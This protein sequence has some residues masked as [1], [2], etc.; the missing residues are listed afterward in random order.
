MKRLAL[1]LFLFAL[2]PG[3]ALA[4]AVTGVG[5][6]L[7]LSL[8]P[9]QAVVG[10]QLEVSDMVTDLD[11]VPDIELGFGDDATV[12]ALNLDLHYRFRLQGSSWAPYV[13]MGMGV[14][15]IEVD[16]P[17]PFEDVSDTEVGGNFILGAQV[18]TQAGSKFFSELK[19]GLGDIPE[20]KILVGWNFKL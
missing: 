4:A 20:V 14:N 11:F 3:T 2:L 8:D 18:P 12:I 9:D 17:S 6:R 19:L 13:G 16:Q 15:F 5:P 7:G 10:G 1:L